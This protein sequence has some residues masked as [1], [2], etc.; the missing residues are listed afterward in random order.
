MTQDFSSMN[1]D[2]RNVI[3]ITLLGLL[4]IHSENLKDFLAPMMKKDRESAAF[5]KFIDELAGYTQIADAIELGLFG[6]E[7]AEVSHGQ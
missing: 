3:G 2:Q 1:R 7:Q 4:I 5:N 6:E